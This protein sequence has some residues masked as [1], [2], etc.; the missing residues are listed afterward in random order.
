MKTN[1]KKPVHVVSLEGGKI[2][3]DGVKF[4]PAEMLKTQ[5]R[6]ENRLNAEQAKEHKQFLREDKKQVSESY[7]GLFNTFNF[8]KKNTKVLT[9]FRAKN[10]KIEAVNVIG[11]MNF[12]EF[13]G[14]IKSGGAYSIGLTFELCARFSNLN[15][16]QRISAI[17]KGQKL[18]GLIMDVKNGTLTFAGAL[19]KYVDLYGLPITTKK[20][21]AKVL[22]MGKT[23]VFFCLANGDENMIS[24][25]RSA[26]PEICAEYD[27]KLLELAGAELVTAT[28]E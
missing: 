4:S 28:N 18:N 6:T 5:K 12:N 7:K 10:S 24:I 1:V 19:A 3:I 27:A 16:G 23:S 17:E 26:K 25:I 11:T 22:V 2:I 9:E 21:G 13:I 15:E 20:D 14:R 8:V